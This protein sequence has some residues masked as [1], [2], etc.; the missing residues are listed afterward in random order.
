MIP[1]PLFKVFRYYKY[2]LLGSLVLG[3]VSLG[4][5]CSVIIGVSGGYVALGILANYLTRQSALYDAAPLIYGAAAMSKN[6][7]FLHRSITR[8]QWRN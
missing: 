2:L 7:T 3:Y 5:W 8:A 4:A 1:N 6:W